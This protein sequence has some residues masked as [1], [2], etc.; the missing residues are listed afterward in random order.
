MRVKTVH[1][2]VSMRERRERMKEFHARVLTV[3]F[4]AAVRYRADM[5]VATFYT[6][7]VVNTVCGTAFRRQDQS[8]CSSA[9]I[10]RTG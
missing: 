3:P 6:R 2:E 10:V 4:G 9:F 8:E 7:Q 5:A 1:Y